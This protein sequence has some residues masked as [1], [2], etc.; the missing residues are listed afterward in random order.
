MSRKKKKTKTL[1]LQEARPVLMMTAMAARRGMRK[2]R[3]GLTKPLAKRTKT[4]LRRFV[5]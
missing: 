5:L 1:Q 4:L 3:M 2:D